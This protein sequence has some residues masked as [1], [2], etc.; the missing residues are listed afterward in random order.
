TGIATLLP[1]GKRPPRVRPPSI[2]LRRR[3]GGDTV[4]APTLKPPSDPATGTPP[5]HPGP[6]EGGR[7][8]P[9]RPVNILLV[10]DQPR[11]LLALEAVVAAPGRNLVKAQ[12]GGEALRCVLHEDFAVILMDVKMPEMDGFETAALIHQRKRSEHTPIIFLTAFQSD[13]A[14]I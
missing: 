14:Q 1:T 11:S 6:G 3:Q 12:S 2:R 4:P 8:G 7:P 13:E 10:H 9:H 5:G